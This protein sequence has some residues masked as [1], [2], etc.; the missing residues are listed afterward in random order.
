MIFTSSYGKS[1]YYCNFLDIREFDYFSKRFILLFGKKWC[2]FF[3]FVTNL[4]R[5][6]SSN[7][8]PEKKITWCR[9]KI[10]KMFKIFLFPEQQQKKQLKWF[11]IRPCLDK[12]T[13]KLEYKKAF[14][15]WWTTWI[16]QFEYVKVKKMTEWKKVICLQTVSK[17]SF[18]LFSWR[19][20]SH[21]WKTFHLFLSLGSIL[22]TAF[23]PVDFYC[24]FCY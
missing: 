17:S 21:R 16:W 5:L 14:S 11:L 22:P 19:N 7:L 10:N 6:Y 20:F 4:I 2:V 18:S 1:S 9:F 13:I 3:I 23:A 12:N 8:V 24:F 15:L